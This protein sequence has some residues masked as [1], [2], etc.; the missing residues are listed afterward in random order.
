MFTTVFITLDLVRGILVPRS[1]L[2][3][4]KRTNEKRMGR[5]KKGINATEEK[6]INEPRIHNTCKY[7]QTSR[8]RP[9]K[10]SSLCGGGRLWVANI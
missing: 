4:T 10:M 3:R 6:K 1:L 7:S 8:K 5:G 2:D 9:P